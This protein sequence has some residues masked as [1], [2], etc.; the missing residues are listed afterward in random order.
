MSIS[1]ANFGLY[2]S[3]LGNRLDCLRKYIDYFAQFD[4]KVGNKFCKFYL[5]LEKYKDKYLLGMYLDSQ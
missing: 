2:S 3:Y 5:H 4:L 1:K